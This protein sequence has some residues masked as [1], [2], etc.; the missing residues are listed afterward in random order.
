MPIAYFEFYIFYFYINP[1]VFTSVRIR[2]LQIKLKQIILINYKRTAYC[3]FRDLMHVY[4][5]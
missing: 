2:Q 3:S 5:N 1:Y 4:D